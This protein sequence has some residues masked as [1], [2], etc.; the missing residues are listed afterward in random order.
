MC[1]SL[2]TLILLA[3]LILSVYAFIII[4]VDILIIIIG[5]LLLFSL[6]LG[7]ILFFFIVWKLAKVVCFF[8]LSSFFVV[9]K[10]HIVLFCV[11][12]SLLIRL[13]IHFFLYS[14]YCFYFDLNYTY[15][16]N[17]CIFCNIYQPRQNLKNFK[18]ILNFTD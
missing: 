7:F 3:C 6:L 17:Q 1:S 12:S 5:W 2:G 14:K 18:N 4:E 9:S 15:K 11:Y 16:P 13:S 8:L 10:L